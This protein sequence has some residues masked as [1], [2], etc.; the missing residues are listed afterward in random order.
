MIDLQR[1]QLSRLF[2]R[3]GDHV[4]GLDRGRLLI[5]FMH[6]GIHVTD[7]G[8]LQQVRIQSRADHNPAKYRLVCLGRTSGH[9]DA[10]NVMLPD[11]LLDFALGVSG[12]GEHLAAGQYHIG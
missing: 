9:D 6:P 11:G 1:L 3:H 12:T 2:D 7:I 8:H 4:H 5:E 10:I